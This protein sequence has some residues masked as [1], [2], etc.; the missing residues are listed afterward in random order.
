MAFI[1]RYDPDA[2]FGYEDPTE[3]TV[4]FL[5]EHELFD[6]G[7]VDLLQWRHAGTDWDGVPSWEDA[8]P[9]LTEDGV[10]IISMKKVLEKGEMINK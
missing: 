9:E 8:N 2:E 7:E 1:L 6:F 5:N 10:A 4:T 3:H